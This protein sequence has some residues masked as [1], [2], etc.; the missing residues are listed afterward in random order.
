MKSTLPGLQAIPDNIA[1]QIIHDPFTFD[2]M[3]AAQFLQDDPQNILVLH[4]TSVYGSNIN[5][6][7]K[8]SEDAA[9]LAYPCVN[10]EPFALG[11]NPANIRTDIALLNLR[12]LGIPI[13]GFIQ[14]RDILSVLNNISP[15]RMYKLLEL[16]AIYPSVYNALNYDILMRG[17]T[18]NVT[19]AAHCQEGQGGAG[20]FFRAIPLFIAYARTHLLWIDPW[21]G[22]QPQTSYQAQAQTPASPFT[23]TYSIAFVN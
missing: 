20:I 15:T 23:K 9:N 3:P 17:R 10:V 19:S 18:T 6:I 2:E 21:R 7:R 1:T 11:P 8:M 14:K 12:K 16:P 4:K 22:T 13:G 5:N